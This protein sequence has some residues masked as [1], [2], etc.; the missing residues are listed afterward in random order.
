M[1]LAA[2][3]QETTCWRRPA[4]FH[5]VALDGCCPRGLEL[6]S[7]SMRPRQA[8]GTWRVQSLD[9]TLGR[10]KCSACGNTVG[11]LLQSPTAAQPK[12]PRIRMLLSRLC[13][14][15]ELPRLSP[16][17]RLREKASTRRSTRPRPPRCCAVASTARSS[18]SQQRSLALTGECLP[19]PLNMHLPG[20]WPVT[21]V[22][23]K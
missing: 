14:T 8:S 23:R 12:H 17:S 6:P 9:L 3:K 2:V 16:Q 22:H 19:C 7:C 11:A 5:G 13:C 10:G 20:P 18:E 4:P 21:L 15:R 1:I